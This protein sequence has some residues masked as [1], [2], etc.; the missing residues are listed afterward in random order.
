VI[1]KKHETPSQERKTGVQAENRSGCLRN[2]NQKPNSRGQLAGQN[3][4]T[5]FSYNHLVTRWKAMEI[6]KKGG[7]MNENPI[8]FTP[9]IRFLQIATNRAAF[10]TVLP[11]RNSI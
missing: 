5:K 9:G 10:E 6:E 8:T 3:R 2:R 4:T 7:L 1:E 11:L